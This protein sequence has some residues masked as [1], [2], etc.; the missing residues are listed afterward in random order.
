MAVQLWPRAL[1]LGN[2]RRWCTGKHKKVEGRHN[3]TH[4]YK[5]PYIE[6]LQFFKWGRDG[7]V[8]TVGTWDKQDLGRLIQ[9]GGKADAGGRNETN[10]REDILY[11]TVL[12]CI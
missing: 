10:V 12:Y 9:V 11:C 3:E 2:Q 6:G 1:E 8:Y 5:C 7:T 4:T